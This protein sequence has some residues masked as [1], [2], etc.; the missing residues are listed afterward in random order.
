MNNNR[1]FIGMVIL[2]MALSSCKDKKDHISGTYVRTIDHEYALGNDTLFIKVINA[3]TYQVEKRS[4]FQRIVKVK[5]KVPALETQKRTWMAMYDK[6][7]KLLREPNQGKVIV[8]SEDKDLL[9][10]GNM[11]YKKVVSNH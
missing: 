1:W 2:S 7:H 3:T 10:M 11:K 4:S 6:D 9:L 5:D 8:F